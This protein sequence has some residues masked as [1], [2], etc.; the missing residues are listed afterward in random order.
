MAD[1]N[2]AADIA[3]EY[4]RIIGA[5][6]NMVVCEIGWDEDADSAISEAIEDAIGDGLVDEDTDESCDIVLLWWRDGDGDLVDMLMDAAR[7][8][9]KGGKIWVLSPG[10]GRPGALPSGEIA[11]SAAQCGMIQT[12]SERLGEWQGACL[13]QRGK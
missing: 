8:L 13:V 10:A 7:P 12:K 2:G 4:A 5:Q 1:T 9:D 11:D 6:E 3:R